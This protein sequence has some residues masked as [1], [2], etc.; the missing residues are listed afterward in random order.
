MENLGK[1]VTSSVMWNYA[2][3]LLAQAVSLLVTVVLS[4]LIAP[5]HFG[6]ISIVTIM[7][8]FCNIFISN[9]FGNALVQAKDAKVPTYNAMFCYSLM[10]SVLL[11]VVIFLTAPLIAGYYE[12]DILVPVIRVMGLR[13]VIASLNTIQHSYLVRRLEFKKFF[14]TTFFGTVLSAVVGIAMAYAG[15]GIWALVAQYLTNVTVDTILLHFTCGWK[16]GK[17]NDWKSAAK[18]LPFGFKLLLSAL[19]KNVYNEISGLIIG[20]QFSVTDLAYYAKGK[21]FPSIVVTNLNSTL[22]RVLFSAMSR[23][24]DNLTGVRNMLRRSLKI[25]LYIIGPLMAGF[26]LC[27]PSM[28]SVVLTDKWLESVPYLQIFSLFFLLKSI[29]NTQLQ[30]VNAMGKS[31]ITLWIETAGTVIGLAGLLFAIFVL[32]SITATILTMCL[33][34]AL[35]VLALSLVNRKLLNYSL[36]E[37]IA[38]FAPTLLVVALMSAAVFGVGLL[39]SRGWV[40][41][42]AQIAV[43]I[44]S[45]VAL[46][47]VFK[48]D[49]FN[50]MLSIIRNILKKKEG[51]AK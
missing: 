24:Q 1:K 49:S 36:K 25:N 10:S 45:Y 2:E 35:C 32:K 22:S 20:K 19:V 30:A 7:I 44:I 40:C 6:A 42:L 29:Q 43:G 23:A 27:A 51:A 38:D 14:I 26:A 47:L 48:L 28:V 17:E 50:Y 15:Y 16:P 18:I 4:R 21:Q 3:R 39:L 8:T 37:Q 34:Q 33:E 13:I 41:L 46:S 5:D 12:L 11:Y 9:G 31:G